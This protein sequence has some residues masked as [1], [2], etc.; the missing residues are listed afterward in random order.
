MPAETYLP[1]LFDNDSIILP[2]ND[3]DSGDEWAFKYWPNNKSRMYVLEGT[4]VFSK[5]HRLE[6]GDYML[7]YRDLVNHNYVIRG[8]RAY[9]EEEEC[10][11]KEAAEM[12]GNKELKRDVDLINQG[13]ASG[14][15]FEEF[16]LLDHTSNFPNMEDMTLMNDNSYFSDILNSFNAWDEFMTNNYPPIPQITYFENLSSEDLSQV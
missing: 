15:E 2:M 11:N 14:A 3:M 13:V 12:G 1:V 16:N 6:A 4:G 8:V 5:K 9:G 10:S 7:L